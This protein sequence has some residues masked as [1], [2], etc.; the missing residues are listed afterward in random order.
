M[1]ELRR[2]HLLL[3]LRHADLAELCPELLARE[4]HQRGAEEGRPRGDAQLRLLFDGEGSGPDARA[5]SLTVTE[6]AL[7]YAWRCRAP[8]PWEI[9]PWFDGCER[10]L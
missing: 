5:A 2:A 1:P 10:A 3:A 6:A 8:S 7:D 4:A 9:M